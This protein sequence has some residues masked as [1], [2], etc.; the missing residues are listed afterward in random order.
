[1][2]LSYEK[3]LEDKSS[4]QSDYKLDIQ[5]KVF[6]ILEDYFKKG[7]LVSHQIDSFNNFIVH[8]IKDINNNQNEID[9]VKN[10]VRYKIT[11][12]DIFIDY[13]S[14]LDGSD[15]DKIIFPNEIRERNLHYESVIYCDIKEQIINKDGTVID[16]NIENRVKIGRIP[17]MV[18]SERCNLNKLNKLEKI[19]VDECMYDRG[20][21][22]L[23]KGNERVLVSQ[24]RNTYNN[25]LVS[26]LKNKDKYEYVANVRSMSVST[27]HSVASK[28]FISE[29]G[30]DI[31]VQ[32]PHIKELI[33]LGL[34]FKCYDYSGDDLYDI[35][36][37]DPEYKLFI[38]YINRSSQHIET[39]EQALEIVGKLTTTIISRD[40]RK[41]TALQILTNE[42]FPHIG[43]N[44][45][46]KEY[47]L[48]IA[49]ICRKLIS[50]YLGKRLVDDLDHLGYKRIETPGILVGEL[51]RTLFKRFINNINSQIEKKKHYPNIT[52]IIYRN[53]VITTGL[54]TCFSTGAWGIQKNSYIRKGVCQLLSRLTYGST[55]SHMRRLVFPVGKEAKNIKLR[56]IHSSQFGY[57]DCVETPEGASSGIVL[58]LSLLTKISKNININ[59]VKRELKKISGFIDINDLDIKLIDITSLY[60][61]FLNGRIIGFCKDKNLYVNKFKILRDIKLFSN[62]I[63]ISYNNL[64]NELLINC[65]SGRA[66]RPLFVVNKKNVKNFSKFILSI[67]N[68]DWNN[69]IDNNIIRYIDSLEIENSVVAMYPHE[70][71]EKNNYDYCEI[72]PSSILGVMSS[73]IPFSHCS[74]SPRNIYQSAMGKQAIGIFAMSYRQRTDTCTHILD[75]PQKQLAM[76]KYAKMMNFDK[77]PS[78][79]NAI[80]AIACYTGQNQE[81]SIIMNKSSIDRG[82][83]NVTTYRTTCLSERKKGTYYNEKICIPYRTGYKASNMSEEFVRR[84]NNYS[85]LDKNGIIHVGCTVN[86]GD[87][88]IG[89]ILIKYQKNGL[90]TIKDESLTAK[91]S[92]INGI[93]DRIINTKTGEGCKLVKIVIRKHRIPEP[94]DK[95]SSTSAQKGTVGM[96][97]RQE[98]MPFND[99]GI[100]PDLIINSHAMPSR[101]TT[102]QLMETVLGKASCLSGELGDSTPF[103]YIPNTLDIASHIC[104]QLKKHGMKE[105]HGW[106][107]MRNGMTGKRFKVKVFM[108]P[109]YYQR[110]KHMVSSKIHARATGKVTSM[111]RQARE[112]RSREGGLRFGEMERDCIIGHGTSRFLRE[113]LYDVSDPYTLTICIDC[114]YTV[115]NHLQ[116]NKCGSNNIKKIYIPYAAKLF[117][118][119]LTALGLK[120]KFGI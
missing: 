96:I 16:K 13:P 79:I 26:K 23:L 15:D 111:T 118:Q 48:Y 86:K 33:T 91:N 34:L 101:M 73:C 77:M 80:V 72:H 1:M 70:V 107:Y 39:K 89:K 94:G 46:K 66:L 88:L 75:Y 18:G 27:G 85:K 113:R 108:G 31:L 60:T 35:I 44:G 116:C 54:R 120:I 104:N 100:S 69:L 71:S 38:M 84:Y 95:F 99:E 20:G 11:F 115:L 92:E 74:Q 50:T 109:T 43:I 93:V 9:I 62:D 4:G 19:N 24:L 103:C 106:E 63:S 30:K 112:G 105:E 49:L 42:I 87:V 37:K 102:N 52:S 68:C 21:Y 110:L 119:E 47:V 76:T 6:V 22:F 2:K 40:R 55:L 57:I 5:N 17:I 8:Y 114:G 51:F 53:N 36:S 117:K 67:E 90:E 12:G 10:D 45:T 28:M 56:Q 59:I 61:I 81:D 14:L 97:Y 64:E 58:N 83:F 3:K 78:G 82:L 41:N 29:D 98:D 7:N 32:I 65:D 25:I